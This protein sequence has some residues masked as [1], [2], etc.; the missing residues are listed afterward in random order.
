MS[1][2][3]A[4]MIIYTVLSI[5]EHEGANAQSLWMA[6]VWSFMTFKWSGGTAHQSYRSLSEVRVHVRERIAAPVAPLFSV[7]WRLVSLSCARR[8]RSVARPLTCRYLKRVQAE[9][10][11]EA[12]ANSAPP[13]APTT[14]VINQ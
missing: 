6:V 10:E 7:C 8:D 11:Q 1:I 3:I 2:S 12:A 9:E 4:A 5:L 13:S 14:V